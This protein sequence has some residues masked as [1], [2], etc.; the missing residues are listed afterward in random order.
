[1]RLIDM[2]KK[3]RERSWTVGEL[4]EPYGISSRTIHR[5]LLELQ[6]EPVYLALECE[7]EAR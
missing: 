2:M 6:G 5:D 7:R 1:M 4:A 3:L